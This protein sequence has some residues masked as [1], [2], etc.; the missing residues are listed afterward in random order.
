MFGFNN[1]LIGCDI[2]THLPLLVVIL[3]LIGLIG[4]K[5]ESRPLH[6]GGRISTSG[7]V[8]WHCFGEEK[9]MDAG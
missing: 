9:M 7:G 6:Q 5:C 1:F 4:N 2:F 3:L 8:W